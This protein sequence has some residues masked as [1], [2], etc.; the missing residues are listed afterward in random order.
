MD[1]LPPGAVTPI[2]RRR[3]PNMHLVTTS[4]ALAALLALATFAADLATYWP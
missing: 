1:P 3:Q 2:H 4:A